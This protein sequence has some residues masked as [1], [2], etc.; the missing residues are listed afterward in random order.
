[1]KGLYETGGSICGLGLGASFAANNRVASGSSMH[2]SDSA[3]SFVV[4]S[5]RRPSSDAG[6]NSAD[7]N[8]YAHPSTNRSANDPNPNTASNSN[9]GADG[10][11]GRFVRDWGSAARN[12][13]LGRQWAADLG[14]YRAPRSGFGKPARTFVSTLFYQEV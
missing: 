13:C 1:M 12:P 2:V 10:S 5:G 3:A 6:S 8:P 4:S 11:G 14:G 7:T 9:F